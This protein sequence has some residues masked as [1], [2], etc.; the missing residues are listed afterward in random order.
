MS[1]NQ[2]V[3]NPS[4]SGSHV[5]I[6]FP[7]SSEHK[8]LVFKYR[9]ILKFPE[10]PSD[11]NLLFN[12]KLVAHLTEED[13]MLGPIVSALQNK[14]EKINANSHY[15][16]HFKKDLHESDGLLYMDRNLVI[17]FTLRNAVMKTLHESHR[18]QFG[19]KYLAQEHRL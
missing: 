11:L 15:L 6:Y 2:I 3:I 7:I 8:K 1:N 9:E 14:V 16:E 4:I 19:M 13:P 17:P 10:R 5:T 18:G 12:A